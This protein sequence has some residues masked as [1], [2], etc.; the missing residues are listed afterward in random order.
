M[1]AYFSGRL[2]QT[3]WKASRL[4]DNFPEWLDRML[5]RRKPIS[6]ADRAA[7]FAALAEQGFAVTISETLN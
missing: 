7:A 2:A 1:T 5:G 4:P 3:D 6:A